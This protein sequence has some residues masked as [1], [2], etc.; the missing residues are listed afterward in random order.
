MKILAMLLVSLILLATIVYADSKNSAPEASSFTSV[1]GGAEAGFTG[2][3]SL[4]VPLITVPGRGINIPI[5]A[6]YSAGIRMDQEASWIGLGWDLGVG[7]ITRNVNNIP[8]D[9]YPGYCTIKDP[10][11]DPP[12]TKDTAALG[13]LYGDAKPDYQDQ[14]SYYLNFPGGGGK[15]FALNDKTNWIMESWR[16]LKIVPEKTAVSLIT[17]WTVTTEDGTQYIFSEAA[18]TRTTNLESRLV[19]LNLFNNA[20]CGSTGICALNT[21]STA[22]DSC[23]YTYAWYLTE[24]HSPD[25]IDSDGVHK[26]YTFHYENIYKY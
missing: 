17:K 8:D 3:L 21:K 2:D 26:A 14:D 24:I 20:E 25:Y 6:G 4:S 7:A 1:G 13:W 5:S 12:Y 23:G 18:Q 19:K 11:Q 22:Q 9:Y 15:F 16:P 10:E